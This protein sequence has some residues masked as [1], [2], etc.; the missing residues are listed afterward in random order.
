MYI[1][2]IYV[3]IG[4]FNHQKR[5]HQAW[6]FFLSPFHIAVSPLLLSLGDLYLSL[7]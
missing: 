3:S 1:Y 7:A 5:N 2:I 6:S 4:G